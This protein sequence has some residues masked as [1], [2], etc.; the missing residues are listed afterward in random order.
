MPC[1]AVQNFRNYSRKT[2]SAKGLFKTDTSRVCSIHISGNDYERD[3]QSKLTGIKRKLTLKTDMVSH[4]FLP[5]VT[6]KEFLKR[7]ISIIQRVN[8]YTKQNLIIPNASIIFGGCNKVKGYIWK[9]SERKTVYL[10]QEL[11]IIEIQ[12]RQ[13][14]ICKLKTKGNFERCIYSKTNRKADL[15]KQKEG[16][17]TF[18]EERWSV[19]TWIINYLKMDSQPVV[20]TCHPKRNRLLSMSSRERLTFLSFNEMRDDY[21]M[22][23]IQR[24]DTKMGPHSNAQV[25]IGR[26]MTSKWKQLI[27]Y[28]F[29]Q[30]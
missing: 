18:A 5:N 21:R 4:L 16:V 15:Q 30:K 1:C 17:F 13:S 29:Q 8:F 22:C 24:E 9:K 12:H 11:I 23:Y 3:L 26:G 20:F 2:G 7:N 25:I 19:I 27:F 14:K 28:D 6:S 10:R